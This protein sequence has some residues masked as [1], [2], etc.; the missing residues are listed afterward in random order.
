M[1]PAFAQQTGTISGLVTATDGSALPGVTVARTYRLRWL[2][3]D[4]VAGLVLIATKDAVSWSDKMHKLSGN[5]GL[6]DGSV[7]QCDSAGLQQY[8]QKLGPITNRLAVP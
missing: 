7:Q 5:F 1:P 3:K 8:F 4:V 2:S 6:A